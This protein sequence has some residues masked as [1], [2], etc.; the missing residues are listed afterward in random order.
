MAWRKPG[1]AFDFSYNG[2]WSHKGTGGNVSYF[3]EAIAYERCK[4]AVEQYH[5]RINAEKYS[6]FVCEQFINLFKK[7]LFQCGDFS[8][9]MV[10]LHRK[11]WKL[12]LPGIGLAFKIYHSSRSPDLNPIE[13]IFHI[14]K[15]RLHQDALDRQITR[16]DFAVF[17]ARVKTTL[18]LIPADSGGQNYPLR[19]QENQRNY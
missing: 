19:G 11:V 3:M 8:C 17:F 5:S 14:V 1:Q 12:D 7:L 18:G 9:I 10:I 2:K 13:N 15:Q 16:E 4:I 6:S